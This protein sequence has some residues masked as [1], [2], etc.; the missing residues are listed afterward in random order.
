[1]KQNIKDYLILILANFILAIATIYLILP[2]NLV[3]GGLSGLSL[4]VSSFIWLDKSILVG[5]LSL[6]LFI[7]GYLFMGFEFAKRPY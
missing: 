5:C 3:I 2:N 4:V 7:I 6:T 1:M